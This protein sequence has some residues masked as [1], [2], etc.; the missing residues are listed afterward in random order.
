[1]SQEVHHR[2]VRRQLQVKQVIQDFMKNFKKEDI[3]LQKKE[4]K[5]LTT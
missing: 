2:I 5:L 1:M 4:S 3:Y